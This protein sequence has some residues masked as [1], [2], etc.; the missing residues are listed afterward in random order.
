MPWGQGEKID[1]AMREIER[2]NV[3]PGWVAMSPDGQNI[4]WSCID[5]GDIPIALRIVK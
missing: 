3:N 2:P 1:A 5:T 4:V